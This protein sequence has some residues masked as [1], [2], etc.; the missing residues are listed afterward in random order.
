MMRK[1]HKQQMKVFNELDNILPK[2]Q[3]KFKGTQKVTGEDAILA[4][5]KEIDGTSIDPEKEY[6]M[7][8]PYSNT[9]NHK[10][11]LKSA[12]R[13]NGIAGVCR[14]LKPYYT[15]EKFGPV[16]VAIFKALS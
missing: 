2:Q 8:M 5:H 16:Q 13:R 9:A 7:N 1:I 12:Y 15:K 11:R 3:Y 14:Y 6:T 4:G 10:N